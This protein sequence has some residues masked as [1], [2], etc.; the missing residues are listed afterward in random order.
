MRKKE[1]E[2]QIKGEGK[3]ASC[4]G[5]NSVCLGGKDLI[6]ANTAKRQEQPTE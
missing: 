1:K 2:Q 3:K 5:L 4:P 6:E